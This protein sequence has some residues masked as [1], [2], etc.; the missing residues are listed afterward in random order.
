MGI[1]NKMPD[2]LTNY[3]PNRE[4]RTCGVPQGSM[5]GLLLFLCYINDLP[6]LLKNSPKF[7]AD[8]TAVYSHAESIDLTLQSLLPYI[9]Q[10]ELWCKQ[11][12]NRLTVSTT[13]TKI[14]LFGSRR[15]I[16]RNHHPQIFLNNPPSRLCW[17]IQI[18]GC[19]IRATLKLQETHAVHIQTSCA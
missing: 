7:Y 14:M 15:F 11:K 1:R 12:Q 19:F 6:S 17:R 8:D 18:P 2:W 4:Q 10:L 5:L 16:S 13:K 9:K 3:L